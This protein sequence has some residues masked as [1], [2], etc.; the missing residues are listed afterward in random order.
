ML[1]WGSDRQVAT[2]PPRRLQWGRDR[3]VADSKATA[4]WTSASKTAAASMGPRPSGRG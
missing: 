2:D 3:Q 4:V 1:Q